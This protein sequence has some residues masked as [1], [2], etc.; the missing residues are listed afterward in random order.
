MD[1][2]LQMVI[3]YALELFGKVTGVIPWAEILAGIHAKAAG[4]PGLLGKIFEEVATKAVNAL[5]FILGDV[6]DISALLTAC[7]AQDWPKA[8]AILKDILEKSTHAH[9]PAL[10]QACNS[11]LQDHCAA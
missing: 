7:A 11:L 4:L 2:L 8:L 10:L 3:M 9:A 1:W 5:E 6:K